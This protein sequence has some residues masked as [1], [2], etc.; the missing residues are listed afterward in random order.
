MLKPSQFSFLLPLT[1]AEGGVR[2]TG[3]I[4]KVLAKAIYLCLPLLFAHP[5]QIVFTDFSGNKDL[6][7]S[8][9]L[10]S[11]YLQ[12]QSKLCSEKS[13]PLTDTLHSLLKSTTVSLERHSPLPRLKRHFFFFPFI[14]RLPKYACFWWIAK[15]NRQTALTNKLS[16]LFSLPW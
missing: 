12:W 6:S 11:S 3:T 8:V 14:Q 13:L 9:M 1:G 4:Q 15:T 16:S 2:L 10:V 5:K 7:Q